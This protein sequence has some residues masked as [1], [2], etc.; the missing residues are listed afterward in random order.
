M[1]PPDQAAGVEEEPGAFERAVGGN[2]GKIELQDSSTGVGAPLNQHSG[3][4]GIRRVTRI[5][6][7]SIDFSDRPVNRR[8]DRCADPRRS[9]KD[10]NIELGRESLRA[11]VS[12]ANPQ[13]EHSAVP[14]TRQVLFVDPQSPRV[15]PAARQNEC[16]VRVTADNAVCDRI[17]V[18]V[19]RSQ[20]PDDRPAGRELFEGED[21][22][23]RDDRR[24]WNIC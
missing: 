6:A 13:I 19:D 9:D 22:R 11:V 10:S 3:S 1:A 18:G 17:P 23:T 15:G 21:R 8:A 2:R 4:C 16:I 14:E 20:I 24:F 7:V 5:K 12:D